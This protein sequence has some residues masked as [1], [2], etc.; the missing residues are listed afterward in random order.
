MISDLVSY[1]IILVYIEV[2]T[3][4]YKI[5]HTLT[6]I[7]DKTTI[8]AILLF[9]VHSTY[10]NIMLNSRRA[11]S[12]TPL[13]FLQVQ[14]SYLMIWCDTDLLANETNEDWPIR[15][16]SQDAPIKAQRP[17]DYA[18]TL[19]DSEDTLARSSSP[20]TPLIWKPACHKKKE[21]QNR[22][23][24]NL[25]RLGKIVSQI[26]SALKIAQKVHEIYNCKWI[27]SVNVN[28]VVLPENCST[29]I[30][31]PQIWS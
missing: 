10:L 3:E 17:T 29:D 14:E 12:E 30:V 9:L 31:T 13:R 16:D 25:E 1:G 19:D 28:I 18:I 2:N 4:E 27:D 11:S 24:V 20:N 23:H 7:F 21:K 8:E 26:V 15:K 6:F 22:N 5:S